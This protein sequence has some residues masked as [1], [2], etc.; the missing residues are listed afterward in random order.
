MKSLCKVVPL[1]TTKKRTP[2]D[3]SRVRRDGS[4]ATLSPFTACC[5]YGRWLNGRSRIPL[6]DTSY[7]RLNKSARLSVR[8]RFNWPGPDWTVWRY[9]LQ[10]PGRLPLTATAA[11]AET[12]PFSNHTLLTASPHCSTPP[13]WTYVSRFFCLRL[14]AQPIRN[15][16]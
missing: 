11:L 6:L 12:I 7:L 14:P 10:S 4:G 5:F 13:R 3:A 2:H 8:D 1:K 15:S 9:L 16:P